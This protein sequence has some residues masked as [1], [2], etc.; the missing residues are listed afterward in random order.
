MTE[1]VNFCMLDFSQQGEDVVCK[2]DCICAVKDN[3]NC[4]A[5]VKS[6]EY[7]RLTACCKDY[8]VFDVTGEFIGEHWAVRDEASRRKGSIYVLTNNHK[9]NIK[10]KVALV[11]AMQLD[12]KTHL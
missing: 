11:P 12:R 6:T 10:Y 2:T 7:T 9:N 5:S 3:C 1:A 4:A 8:I